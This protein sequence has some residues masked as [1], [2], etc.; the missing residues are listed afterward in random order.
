MI[1][2]FVAIPLPFDVMAQLTS[3]QSGLSNARWIDGENMHLT[4][5]FMG[6]VLEPD[7]DDIA[8]ELSKIIEP[9]FAIELSGIG[10]FERRG[11]AHSIW[12]RVK[13][14]DPLLHLQAKIERTLVGCGLAP[15]T[16]KYTPHVTLARMHDTPVERLAPWLETIGD[17][18][19]PAF[20]ANHFVLVETVRG[21]GAAKYID[22]AEYDL[23]ELL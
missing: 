2:L 16:R 23:Y 13:K 18:G 21:H 12:V 3:L 6:D 15:E 17:F 20:I 5:R 9:A 11:S 22:V 19:V 1:R 14:S 10:Y 8:A 7:V 4:M